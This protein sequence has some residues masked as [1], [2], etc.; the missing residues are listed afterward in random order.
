MKHVL[1]CVIKYLLVVFF[2]EGSHALLIME[3]KMR[4]RWRRRFI[5]L[6]RYSSMNGESE[7]YETTHELPNIER[8]FAIS[9]LH[10]DN[11]SNISWL[12]RYC[13]S[14]K[15]NIP[16]ENDA[17]IIAGDISHEI[18]TLTKSLE[19][20]QNSLSCTIFF[21]PGNHEAWLTEKDESN[22]NVKNSIEKL[23]VIKRKC[24]EMGVFT[25]PCLLGT[26]QKAWVVPI[27]SWYDN[28]LDL[29]YDDLT[30]DFRYW[31]WVDFRLCSWPVHFLDESSRIPS[32]DLTQFF[33]RINNRFLP[34][35]QKSLQ[36]S[37]DDKGLI[38]FS[39]FL[40]CS[41]TL[42]DY[43]DLSCS[44][45]Q[46]EWLYDHGQPGL[47]AKFAKVSGSKYIDSYIRSFYASSTIK[48]HIHIFG[49]S[50]RPKDFYF[51]N[52]RYIHN[53]L[54][55]PMERELFL[56]NPYPKFQCIWDTTTREGI[57]P[58]NSLVVRYWEQYGG[59]ITG[60]RNKVLERKRKRSMFLKKMK[61]K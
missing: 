23:A 55:K 7:M 25:D 42:P 52:I 11:I 10:T 22:Y 36:N 34:I 31:P 54:G 13:Q 33:L 40:P 15:E 41:Q 48:N 16:N 56:C 2:K 14:G 35:I 19:I 61:V 29:G 32:K 57:V 58:S 49:H 46:K 44:K 9:D 39:H 6:L 38:T 24:N 17:V 59:G 51:N 20:I 27:L 60:L 47:S 50:H 45:L 8:I 30:D 21:V 4:Q 12:R 43:K 18:S 26:H 3:S 53:P 28:T 5:P 1:L 37:R